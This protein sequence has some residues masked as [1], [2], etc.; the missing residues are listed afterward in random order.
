MQEKLI[1]FDTAKLAKQKGFNVKT[2]WA[3][4]K[5]GEEQY[6][7][8]DEEDNNMYNHNLWDNYSRPTQSLLVKWLREIHQISVKIDD[9]YT[10]SKIRYG[11][12]VCELGSQD[13]N[14]QGIFITYEK[15]LEAGLKKALKK[16]NKNDKIKLE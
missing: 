2:I 3:F 5:E 1:E 4:T 15:A 10:N 8:G 12:N 7:S 14:P 9:F 6:S 11:F 16:I 13:D